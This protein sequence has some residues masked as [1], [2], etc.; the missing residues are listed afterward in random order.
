MRGWSRRRRESELVAQEEFRHVRRMAAEDVTVLGEQLAE[1]HVETLTDDLGHEATRHYQQALDGYERAKSALDAA[2]EAEQVGA[3]DAELREARYQRACV[4]ALRD[5]EPLPER[6]GP[7]F[8]N[9][10]HGPSRTEVSWAPPQG[11]ERQVEVCG[12]C[13]QR[14]SGGLAVDVRLVRVG[15]RYVPWWQSGAANPHEAV[16]AH[17]HGGHGDS[18]SAHAA[19]AQ[20]RAGQSGINNLGGAGFGGGFPI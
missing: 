7:C 15:D 5:G 4:L 1:L 9:P 13:T 18:T 17:V 6:R 11:V 8:F 10:Q 20:A 19:E 2:T 3:V 16:R 14:L 12:S